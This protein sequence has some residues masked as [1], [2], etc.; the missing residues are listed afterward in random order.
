MKFTGLSD[1]R[2]PVIIRSALRIVAFSAPLALSACHQKPAPAAARP[3]EV[4]VVQVLQRD[5]PVIH[6]WVG[7]ADG[8]VNATIRA[9]VTGYL[10][11][12]DYHEGDMVDKGQV[13]FEIDPRPFRATLD[14]ARSILAQM[15]AVHENAQLNLGRVQPLAAE[16]ALS[17]KDLDDAIASE[18][19]AAAQVLAA[20]AQVEKAKL[21]LGFT[22]ISSLISGMA[23]LAKAQVGDLVGPAV[24]GGELTTVSTIDPIKIY[25][26]INEQAYIN[27]MRQFS[28]ES[29]GLEAAKKLRVELIL[30]DGTRYPQLGRFY[31]IDRQ[32]DVRTGTF[33]VAAIFPNPTKLLRP[34]QFVRVKVYIGTRPRALLVPQR[35]VNELQGSYQ[36][37]VVGPDNK[38]EMRPVKPGDRVDSLWVIEEG[39]RPGESVVAEGL[40]KVKPGIVVQP[41][42]FVA[43]A[44][45]I[46][47]QGG[48]A[49]SGGTG[50]GSGAGSGAGTGGGTGTGSSSSS[51]VGNAP[52]GNVQGGNVAGGNAQAGSGPGGNAPGSGP[53]GVGR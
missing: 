22:K 48:G 3:P 26:T 17:K 25:Y 29:A 51:S 46:N 47:P 14:Q 11:R 38:V 10:V 44:T 20:R 35:A 36:V 52:G 49:A 18:R 50:A 8:L 24:Q 1:S 4:E 9:Q 31:A 37:A 34:G 27:F 16:N 5:I 43:T 21:D 33:R 7:S 42:P 12:Q 53:A 40:Q 19:S 41:K 13:L 32:V 23:G 28:S 39:L 45:A 2:F 6:E 15:E 30:G